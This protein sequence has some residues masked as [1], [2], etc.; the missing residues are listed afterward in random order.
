MLVDPALKGISPSHRQDRQDSPDKHDDDNNNNGGQGQKDEDK[1][2]HGANQ[3]KPEPQQEARNIA[4]IPQQSAEGGQG[5]KGRTRTKA[6]KR[7]DC[8]QRQKAA[9]AKNKEDSAAL[10]LTL[11]QVLRSSEEKDRVAQAMGYDP[12]PAHPNTGEQAKKDI[13]DVVAA[14]ARALHPVST[15]REGAIPKTVKTVIAQQKKGGKRGAGE[16]SEASQ[17]PK[18]VKQLSIYPPD[19]RAIRAAYL[20]GSSNVPNVSSGFA[21]RYNNY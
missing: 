11:D 17:Q 2:D 10:A 8:R 1:Q 5:Q 3:H 15:S 6:E 4:D 13:R 12:S 19:Y 14:A 21:L 20:S 7:R 16:P 9:A 18:K